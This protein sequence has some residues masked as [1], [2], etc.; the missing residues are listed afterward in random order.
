MRVEIGDLGADQRK[1]LG[2]GF[3]HGLPRGCRRRKNPRPAKRD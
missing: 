2:E 1:V 3:G